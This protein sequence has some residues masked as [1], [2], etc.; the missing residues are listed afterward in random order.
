MEKRL[1]D[2][3]EMSVRDLEA[4][5]EE[6]RAEIVNIDILGRAAAAARQWQQALDLDDER[7]RVA[8]QLSL[9]QGYRDQARSRRC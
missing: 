3:D 2:Y 5:I 8:D 4:E 1:I 7:A 9:A 6:R